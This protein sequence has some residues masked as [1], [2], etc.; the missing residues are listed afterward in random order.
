MKKATI[1]TATLFLLLGAGGVRAQHYV[2]IRAGYGSGSVRI[3]PP[4]ETGMIWGLYSGGVSWKYYSPVK[5]VGAVEADLEFMQRGYKELMKGGFPYLP[6]DTTTTYHR[7]VNSLMLPLI[8]QPHFYFFKRTM[9]V[10]INLGLT[11]SYNIDSR[12][13]WHSEWSGL[14]E[15]K[16]YRMEL[17]R[18]NRWGYGLCGGAGIGF[19]L[20][21]LEL[22]FEGRY[23][24][25]YSDIL[26]N[27]N[28][29]ED[30]PLRSPLDNINISVGL[31]WRLG[32][33]GILS[34]PSDRVAE[35]LR[36]RE[37]KQM[38]RDEEAARTD[39]TAP[40]TGKTAEGNSGDQIRSQ[41]GPENGQDD[42]ATAPADNEKTNDHGDDETTKDS[43]AD[44]ERHQ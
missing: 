36:R 22:M 18:D 23:Y 29:Y 4:T 5:Y 27:R 24:F 35:K 2:G 33:G 10:F 19:L 13:E 16:P 37:K 30:N 39:R 34:A 32:K 21:R 9:R 42:P 31:Y 8:W 1:I 25:G 3:F 12:Y 40:D 28:K 43:P 44:T 20:G 26:K 15:S 6:D 11:F 14:L 17:T 41:T 7:T 38:A